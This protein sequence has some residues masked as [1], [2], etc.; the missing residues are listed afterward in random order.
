MPRRKNLSGG[1][2]SS[3]LSC[4]A[5]AYGSFDKIKASYFY[6]GKKKMRMLYVIVWSLW[7][8]GRIYIFGKL[9][10]TGVKDGVRKNMGKIIVGLSILHIAAVILQS[11]VSYTIIN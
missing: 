11:L 4:L 8:M 7:V 6:E 9:K 10:T 2:R 1:L 3:S 5:E